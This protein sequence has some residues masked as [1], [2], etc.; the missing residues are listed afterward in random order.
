VRA[1]GIVKLLAPR[2][3]P[4]AVVLSDDVWAFRGNDQEYLAYIRD[5]ATGYDPMIVPLKGGREYS[6]RR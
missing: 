1:L 4:G 3:R 2:M 5:P 6:V